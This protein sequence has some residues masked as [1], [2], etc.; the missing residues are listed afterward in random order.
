MTQLFYRIA[1]LIKE[2]EMTQL[3]YRIAQVAKE[4]TSGQKNVIITD[5]NPFSVMSGIH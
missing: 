4:K 5:S 1:Q 2:K 3:F